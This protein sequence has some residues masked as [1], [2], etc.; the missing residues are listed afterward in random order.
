MI[1]VLKSTIDDNWG[2]PSQEDIGSPRR[3][4]TTGGNIHSNMNNKSVADVKSTTR[5]KKVDRELER[6]SLTKDLDSGYFNNGK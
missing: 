6:S 4:Y 5:F 2:G 3:V 1:N